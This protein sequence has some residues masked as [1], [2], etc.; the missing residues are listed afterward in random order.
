MNK[1]INSDSEVFDWLKKYKRSVNISK[2]SNEVNIRISLV[3]KARPVIK[4]YIEANGFVVFLGTYSRCK[5]ETQLTS[6][7]FRN[8]SGSTKISTQNRYPSE[9]HHLS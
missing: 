5:V 8:L 7:E 1:L 4:E 9:I 3:A 6:I 2:T